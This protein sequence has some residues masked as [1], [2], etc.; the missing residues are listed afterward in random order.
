VSVQNTFKHFGKKVL[1]LP[2]PKVANLCGNLGIVPRKISHS[3][4]ALGDRVQ[5]GNVQRKLL[6]ITSLKFIA[7]R[8][9]TI[10]TGKLCLLSLVSTGNPAILR[11]KVAGACDPIT[12]GVR[13][14]FTEVKLSRPL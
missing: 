2:I 8:V 13:E 1:T 11:M 7:G 9:Q 12:F 6:S 14:N 3:Q 5:V 10:I 4:H